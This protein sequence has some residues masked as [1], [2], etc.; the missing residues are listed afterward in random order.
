M[1]EGTAAIGVFDSGV[2][3]LTVLRRLSERLPNEH[4]VYLGDTARVPYGTK[5]PDTV[6]KYARACTHLLAQSGI[7]LLVVACNT[8]SAYALDVLRDEVDYPVVGVVAPGARAA[9]ART[10]TKRIGVIGTTGTIQSGAYEDAITSAAPDVKVFCKACPLFVPLAEEGWTTGAVPRQVAAEYLGELLENDI[11]TLVLGCTHYPLLAPVIAEI[12]GDRVTLVDSAEATAEV[13]AEV[14]A[15]LGLANDPSPH[16][17]L[18]LMVT[19]APA[20]FEKLGRR[21]LGWEP[22]HVEWVDLN[23]C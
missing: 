14:I 17:N 10:K 6:I 23:G 13:V 20:T 19:D 9:L 11:D 18:R 8:A 3:G 5:S 4:L 15:G 2:G 12:A 22:G 21:F 16:R 7:K 1:G